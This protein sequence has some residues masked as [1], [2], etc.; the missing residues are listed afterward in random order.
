MKDLENISTLPPEGADKK[1]CKAALKEYHKK[2][3]ELQNKLYADGTQGL[4]I[5]LQGTDTAGK[6]GTIRHVM[7][8]MNP[9]G[10]H[11][12]SFKKPTEE[13]AKHDF[14]W[15]IY[16]HIPARGMI[17]VFN[18]SY[19]EDVIVPTV[20]Q[21]LNKEQLAERYTIIKQLE[22]HLKASGIHVLKFFLHISAEEQK[23]KIRERLLKPHKKWKYS[24][25]DTKAIRNWDENLA[26][27]NEVL[28]TSDN[29]QWLIVPSDKKWYRNYLVAKT[30]AEYMENMDLKY[31]G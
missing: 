1:T 22:N 11:V 12:Q 10:V 6:D 25:E 29:P 27:Y 21:S 23:E 20:N 9:Q 8:C 30:I 14:L 7:T 13:E 16:P 17:G 24:R 4:L 5:V 2:L 26:A 15:R 19:Y 28:K 18:R 3:Y 31:P